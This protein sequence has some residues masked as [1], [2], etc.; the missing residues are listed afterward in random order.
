MT[1]SNV[2]V[3]TLRANSSVSP[4]TIDRIVSADGTRWATSRSYKVSTGFGRYDIIV[5]WTLKQRV[6]GKI[7]TVS[8]HRSEAA[9]AA[10]V[11][12]VAA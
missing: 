6:N 4:E 10:F 7:V 2:K 8:L 3:S 12:Q 9:A 11:A 5:A 1:T